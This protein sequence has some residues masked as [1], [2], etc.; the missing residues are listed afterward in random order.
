MRRSNAAE[1]CMNDIA[2]DWTTLAQR[3]STQGI[4]AQPA[5]DGGLSRLGFDR[6]RSSVENIFQQL[7]TTS[8]PTRKEGHPK[9]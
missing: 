4:T 8:Q 2:R 6:V 7:N 5:L 9:S 1:Y 3:K